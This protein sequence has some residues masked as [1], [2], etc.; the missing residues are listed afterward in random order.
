MLAMLKNSKDA[1]KE[2][3]IAN[4]EEKKVQELNEAQEELREKKERDIG[5]LKKGYNERCTEIKIDIKAV[6]DILRQKIIN[7]GI[8]SKVKEI[9]EKIKKMKD[10]D[11]EEE[12]DEENKG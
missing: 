12:K 1:K 5:E 3:K 8:Q 11:R 7:D 10:K 6:R 2:E 4:Y 9:Q